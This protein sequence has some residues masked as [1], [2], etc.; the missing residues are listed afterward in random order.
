[1]LKCFNNRLD[2]CCS[3]DDRLTRTM[4]GEH[5]PINMAMSAEVDIPQGGAS[6]IKKILGG[7]A[8]ALVV[9]VGLVAAFH[10][11]SPATTISTELVR[12]PWLVSR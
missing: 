1:M 8:L 7:S 2:I 3:C 9:I 11:G 10:S 12:S 4:S 6:N 5:C